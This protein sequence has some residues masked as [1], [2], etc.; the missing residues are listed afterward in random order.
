MEEQIKKIE[1][2]DAYFGPLY[3]YVLNEDITDIDYNGRELWLTNSK[4]CRYLCEDTHLTEGFVEQFTKRVA[5]TVSQ[6]FHKQNP[7]LEAE[8]DKLRITVVHESVALTGRSFCIRKS[9]PKVRLKEE[10]MLSSGY[11]SREIHD[12]LKNCVRSRLCITFCGEPGAG[13]TECAKYFSQFI[14]EQD[15]VVTIEDT[16]EWHYSECNP[17]HDTVELKVS[18]IMDYT[19]AIKTCLR[20]NPKW[21]FLSEV[22]SKEV[23]Y[24]IEGFST[25][26]KGITTIHTDDVRKVPDRMLNMAGRERSETRMENDIYAFLDVAVLIRRKEVLLPNGRTEIRRSIEQV[27]MFYREDKENRF[28][29]IAEDGELMVDALPPEFAKKFA[30]A[31]IHNPFC[32]KEN[33]EKPAEHFILLTEDEGLRKNREDSV[34]QMMARLEERTGERGTYLGQKSAI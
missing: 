18:D 4:N 14:P 10:T 29:M 31:G 1:E 8:T 12:F 26:V 11:C 22:R 7:V 23:L 5:N 28:L 27:G 19:R 20:L 33:E 2:T 6:P 3:P 32:A 17:E 9:L 13:K 16:P 25:G 34:R 15:R 21:M 30:E 24:L